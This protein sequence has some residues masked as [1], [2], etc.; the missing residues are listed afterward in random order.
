MVQRKLLAR[1]INMK[2]REEYISR[3]K[4][5]KTNYERNIFEG[6]EEL[7]AVIIYMEKRIKDLEIKEIMDGT[8]E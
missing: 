8:L 2:L 4:A 7:N 3:L 5:R 1:S 6:K